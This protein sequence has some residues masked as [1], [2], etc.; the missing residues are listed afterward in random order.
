MLSLS[1]IIARAIGDPVWDADMVALGAAAPKTL[2]YPLAIAY[3]AVLEMEDLQMT[4]EEI[5]ERRRQYYKARTPEQ[6][7]AYRA[8]SAEWFAARAAKRAAERAAEG[9]EPRRRLTA[10]EREASHQ[11]RLRARRESREANIEVE[12]E[13]ERVKA[14]KRALLDGTAISADI[15]RPKAAPLTEDEKRERR[16]MK[17][18][19]WRAENRERAREI[20]RESMKRIAAARAVAEGRVP[21]KPGRP[22]IQTDEQR[23]ARRKATTERWNAANET[24]YLERA[25]LR[26][27][28]KRAG[29]FVSRAKKRL[30]TEERRL[31]EVAWASLRRARIRNAGG[32]YTKDDI[33][34]LLIAQES[35]CA[36]CGQPF[37]GDGYH[38]DHYIA[39]ARGG[40]NDPSN[41][42][43]THPVCN[44]RKG[45]KLPDELD[46]LTAAHPPDQKGD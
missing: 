5:R 44:L 17:S 45:A 4:D 21:G 42:K 1:A 41:L 23:R 11:D 22:R 35:K 37:G 26:E 28:A 16:R 36:L 9:L 39:L 25:R 34:A 6:K 27:A 8:K 24:V 38:V 18:A 31:T 29:T 33:I 7:A 12:R 10:E 14:R 46:F 19:K 20:T 32:S 15:S 40:T 43:L 13:K 2:A 30:T 3:P